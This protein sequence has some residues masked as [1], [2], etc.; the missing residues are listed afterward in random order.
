M[1]DRC[2][3]MYM[4]EKSCRL[5]THG[6]RY[7]YD[8]LIRHTFPQVKVI[9]WIGLKKPDIKVLIVTKGYFNFSLISQISA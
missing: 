5:R 9:N 6:Y 7:R 8:I 3:Y 1:R 4:D 2:I